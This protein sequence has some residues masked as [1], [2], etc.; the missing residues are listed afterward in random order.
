MVSTT[1]Q[2][3]AQAGCQRQRHHTGDHHGNR[4]R[5]RE[6]AIQFPRQ[7]T[8]KSDGHKHRRQCQHDGHHR[9]SHLVH[10][11]H[12]RV[13]CADAF[14]AHNALDVFQH[15]DGIIN[16]NADGEH[17]AKQRQCVDRVPQQHQPGE[18]ADQ[19]YRHRHERNQRGAPILQKHKHHQEH[20][21][22]GLGQRLHH[23]AYRHFDKARSVV[24]HVMLKARRIGFG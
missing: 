21:R 2:H 5:H 3:H 1:Q 20:Q 11:L 10:G 18:S 4:N 9:A 6:L 7:A 13:M 8:Q 24:H 17:H 15:H 23:L 12:R 19:R 16:H 22:H 14:L